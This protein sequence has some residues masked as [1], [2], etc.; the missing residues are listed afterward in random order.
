MTSRNVS[1][2]QVVAAYAFKY[3]CSFYD[4]AGEKFPALKV[5]SSENS[6][7]AALQTAIIAATLIL[8]ERRSGEVARGELHA[9]VARSFPPSVQA[10]QLAALRDLSTALRAPGPGA[11]DAALVQALGRWLARAVTKK[12][13]LGEPEQALAAAM[14]RSAWTSAAMIMRLLHPK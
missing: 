1:P 2:G 5:Y 3:A 6:R 14:G 13:E 7:G 9:G 4:F 10:R 8:T 11:P 12:T